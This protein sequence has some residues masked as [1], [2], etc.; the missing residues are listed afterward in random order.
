MTTILV[1]VVGSSCWGWRLRSRPV[2]QPGLGGVL[3]LVLIIVLILW[4]TGNLGACDEL[5]LATGS[6]C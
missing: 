5:R 4:L 3:G 6:S 2:G 1:I